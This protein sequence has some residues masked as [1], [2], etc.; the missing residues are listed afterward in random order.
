MRRIFATLWAMVPLAWAAT[1]V[2]GQTTAAGGGA[3]AITFSTNTYNFGRIQ[4]GDVVKYSFYFTNSGT[5]RLDILDVKPG[6]GCT[7]AGSWDK[8]VEPGKWGA[9]PLQFNSAGFGGSIHKSATV[10][11]NVP[12]NTN[13]LLHLQGEVW[14]PIEVTPQMLTFVFQ[15]ENP[16]N[17]VRSVRIVNNTDEDITLNAPECANT[18]FQSELKPVKPGREWEL[19]VTALASMPPPTQLATLMIRTSSTKVPTFNV[20]AYA[21]V[22]PLIVAAPSQITLP[23]GPLKQP[24]STR[25]SVRNNSSAAVVIS[26]VAINAPGAQARLEIAS[27]G[28]SFVVNVVFPADFQASPGQMFELTMKTDHPKAPL[29]RVPIYQTQP[30]MPVNTAMRPATAPAKPQALPVPVRPLVTP[31]AAVKQGPPPVPE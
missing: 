12:G 26:D 9:I 18:F 6:C 7:T 30:P 24:F 11:C 13:L 15:G 8:Q 20:T 14:K 21:T 29:L 23:A 3:P 10:V 27:D 2:V 16:T 31:R 22:P 28:K 1:N 17:M 19:Q 25:V 4:Q 5:A